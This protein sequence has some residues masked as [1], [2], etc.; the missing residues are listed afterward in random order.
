MGNNEEHVWG[1]SEKHKNFRDQEEYELKSFLG[2][3]G[4]I[5]E[6]QGICPKK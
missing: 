6:E 3:R 4:F 5:N 1:S 2:T